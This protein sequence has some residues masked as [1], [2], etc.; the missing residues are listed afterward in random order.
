[1]KCTVDLDPFGSK[2]ILCGKPVV[3]FFRSGAAN[4]VLYRCQ[5]HASYLPTKFIEIS[6]V[7]AAVIE[8]HQS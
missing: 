4:E 8:V 2:H 7:E 3:R 6:E 1:M 5:N